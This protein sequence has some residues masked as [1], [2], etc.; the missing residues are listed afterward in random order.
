MWCT[1]TFLG[2][3]PIFLQCISPI[4][5]PKPPG[6]LWLQ[7]IQEHTEELCLPSC[8]RKEVL[9][10]YLATL[11]KIR[12]SKA[13]R[14][15]QVPSAAQPVWPSQGFPIHLLPLLQACI[16]AAAWEGWAIKSHPI[17]K[18]G[19]KLGKQSW[20]PKLIYRSA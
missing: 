15:Q 8:A 3:I 14:R 2:A 7:P 13:V 10:Q 12:P 1:S 20:E 9:P 6:L 19:E 16:P 11:L 17:S 5:L 18:G 4:A